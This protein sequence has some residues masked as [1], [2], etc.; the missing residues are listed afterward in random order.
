[1]GQGR[2]FGLVI[3]W[4]APV[5]SVGRFAT[6]SS[7]L[8]GIEI[9]ATRPLCGSVTPAFATSS[10][11]K[12]AFAR[13]RARMECIHPLRDDFG[14]IAVIA[15]VLLQSPKKPEVIQLPLPSAAE[16]ARALPTHP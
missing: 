5:V 1:M 11:D 6:D 3:H 8:R 12:I 9:P 13:D 15:P 14:S 16:Q 7:G 10:V 4:V 2:S